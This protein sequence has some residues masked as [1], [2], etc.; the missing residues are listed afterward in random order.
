MKRY[1]L[2]VCRVVSEYGVVSLVLCANKR[3]LL[4]Y[5]STSKYD[6][7]KVGEIQESC[8]AIT[9]Y[10]EDIRVKVCN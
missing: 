3:K 7:F 4:E 6:D 8:F 10:D 5:V 2:Y 1:Y 9:K